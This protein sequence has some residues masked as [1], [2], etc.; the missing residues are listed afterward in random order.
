MQTCAVALI[1]LLDASQ[2][3]GAKDWESQVDMTAS[4]FLHPEVASVIE[5]NPYGTAVAAAVFATDFAIVVP[6][7]ILTHTQSI[8]NFAAS[9]RGIPRTGVGV[10][11]HIEN[12]LIGT[13]KYMDEA[14]CKPTMKVVDVS[15]DGVINLE[16]D[17]S[18]QRDKMHEKEIRINAIGFGPALDLEKSLTDHLIT[19]GGFTVIA[20]SWMDYA[21]SIRRKLIREIAWR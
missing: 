1:L 7:Q 18:R 3:V 12:A 19:P 9:L 21:I 5:N 13:E 16:Q 15:T 17:A 4:A 14:P 8:D 11:T 2:S 20:H 6:W 10:Y